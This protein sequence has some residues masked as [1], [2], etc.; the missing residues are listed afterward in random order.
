MANEYFERFQPGEIR[1]QM[2]ASFRDSLRT[3]IDPQSGVPYT[4]DVIRLVTLQDGR[5]WV[6]ANDID[7]VMLGVQRRDFFLG[8][9]IDPRLSSSSFLE[10]YHGP[11]YSLPR[12]AA[13]G[14][15][16]LVSAP[17]VTGTTFIGSSDIPNELAT[18]ARDAAGLRYQVFAD[19]V[20]N[21]DGIAYCTLVGIDTG[22]ATNLEVG[23]QLTWIN[24]PGGSEL[25][26]TVVAENFR[27]GVP[28]ETDQEWG[29]RLFE[30][31]GRRPRAGNPA[32]FMLWARRALNAV[33][34]AFVYPCALNAG[35]V[36]VCI[37]QKRGITTGPLARI[38]GLVTTTVVGGYLTPPGSPVVPGRVHVVVVAAVAQPVNAALVLGLAKGL[39]SGWKQSTPW[40][41]FVSVAS[42]I[43][44]LTT[45]KAFRIH[46]DT[47]KPSVGVPELMVWND[48]TSAFE[49]LAVASVTAAGGDNYDVVLATAPEKTLVVGDYISPYTPRHA[50]IARG[51]GGYFDSLGPGEVVDLNS[52]MRAA[53]AFRRPIPQQNFPSSFT[54]DVVEFI[55]E[56][57]G[58]AIPGSSI[59]AL[60]QSAPTLPA[61]VST[62]PGLLV[63]GK[64][65]IYATS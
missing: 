59:G 1:E 30:A 4:E 63:A 46:S 26:C 60:S 14:G 28:E 9:Q 37:T 58:S 57:I 44:T 3:L 55:R 21:A 11:A 51:V 39:P 22:S 42:T 20:A 12:L 7:L 61:T 13:S 43:G 18:K 52:D 15:S 23:A 16:G 47:A 6:E 31:R 32:H 10:N 56:A 40:P 29:N 36:V 41:G 33:E 62:G 64:I 38:A 25:K 49:R 48:A 45:Q 54:S 19:A 17:A 65:G 35:S 24:P 27:G 5:Y 34:Q 53:R 2:L 50:S 8:Q